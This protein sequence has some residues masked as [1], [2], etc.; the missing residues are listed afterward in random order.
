M[1]IEL[2]EEEKNIWLKHYVAS[3]LALVNAKWLKHYVGPRLA[4]V[5]AK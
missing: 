1:A 4:L 5:N 2:K 3:R